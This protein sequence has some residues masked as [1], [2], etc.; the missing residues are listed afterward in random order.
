VNR[1]LRLFSTVLLILFVVSA[2]TVTADHPA[3]L[4][5]SERLIIE[6][7]IA[8]LEGLKEARFVRNGKAYPPATA[9]KFLRAKWKDRA[10]EVR[11]AEDFVERIASRSSTTGR[12]Y[13]VRFSDG[14]ETPT[15]TLLHAELQRIRGGKAADG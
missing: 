2:T 7:L 8:R 5:E 6:K 11:T 10:S 14:R 13:L 9:G 15:S 1:S 12:A 4:P 3:T